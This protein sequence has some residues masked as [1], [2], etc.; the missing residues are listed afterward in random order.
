[1]KKV[2][3]LIIFILCFL[4]V[5]LLSLFLFIQ[6]KEDDVVT[7]NDYSSVI[8]NNS[9]WVTLDKSDFNSLI[10][11]TYSNN[12]LDIISSLENAIPVIFE[13]N[14]GQF[15][16]DNKNNFI[17]VSAFDTNNTVLAYAKVDDG[18]EKFNSS[19]EEILENATR[20]FIINDEEAVR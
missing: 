18:Y 5:L 1:M 16:K 8:L 19:L 3:L 14:G 13:V 15:S 17:V 10:L 11:M 6:P 7:Y 9:S 12:I 20:F 4:L 2:Y